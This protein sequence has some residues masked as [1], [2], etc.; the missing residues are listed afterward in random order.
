MSHAPGKREGGPGVD[1]K[2]LFRTLNG[3][4]YPT[5]QT[6]STTFMSKETSTFAD[7][8]RWSKQNDP[9]GNISIDARGIIFQPNAA[10]Q[11]VRGTLLTGLVVGR[12]HRIRW[13][14]RSGTSAVRLRFAAGQ[15]IADAVVTNGWLGNDFI[16]T[17]TSA[18]IEVMCIGSAG[19][20]AHVDVVDIED[21]TD[22]IYHIFGIGGQS[23]EESASSGPPDMD[24]D[25]PHPKVAAMWGTT[26]SGYLTTAGGISAMRAPV[27]MITGGNTG[28]GPA[29]SFLRY[30]ADNWPG[31]LPANHKLLGVAVAQG[32]TGLISGGAVWAKAGNAAR[33][34]TL[35][36]YMRAAKALDPSNVYSGVRFSQGDADVGIYG[37]PNYL[38]AYPQFVGDV[39]GDL[40]VP[41]MPFF[42]S[43]IKAEGA[44]S[45]KLE[46]I[47]AQKSMDIAGA[48][49]VSR[50][51][52][53]EWNPA[54]GDPTQYND[55]FEGHPHFIADAE[56]IRGLIAG[57]DAI[58]RATLV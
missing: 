56:R 7:L 57:M 8:T 24:I 1:L 33:F 41:D 32:G 53:T 44:S 54:W 46:M 18:F 5:Y 52:Y 6:P 55:D 48:N 22:D 19:S 13:R 9:G 21:V 38:G 2:A 40:G 28:L 23:T 47:A 11:I 30:L 34:N 35:I 36:S 25:L 45:L 12:K 15:N 42:V 17:A 20:G 3:G 51:Y 31:G 14:K 4:V 26:S 16:A 39:R 29:L 58:S 10:T 49:P 37:A 27:Q 43:G 50:N